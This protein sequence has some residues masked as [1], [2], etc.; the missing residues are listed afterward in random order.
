MRSP[1][2]KYFFFN[3]RTK[4]IETLRLHSEAGMVL[5]WSC[6]RVLSSAD[7]AE[8]LV[9]V[10]HDALWEG[11]TTTK[12][13][14]LALRCVLE[15]EVKGF[16]HRGESKR[17]KKIAIPRWSEVFL[18]SSKIFVGKN[19]LVCVKSCV[20][21]IFVNILSRETSVFMAVLVCF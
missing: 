18:F 20:F 11:V 16:L 9:F 4:Y 1:F 14:S 3:W 10:Y 2:V 12:L 15:D 13:H 7:Q 6:Y 5:P 21:S 17:E 8:P 19:T